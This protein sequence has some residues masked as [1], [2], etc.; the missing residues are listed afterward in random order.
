MA[1]LPAFTPAALA[2]SKDLRTRGF[3]FVGPTIVYAFL[4]SIGWVDDHLPSCFRYG[5]A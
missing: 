2:L 4:Q 1:D 3:R 5:A